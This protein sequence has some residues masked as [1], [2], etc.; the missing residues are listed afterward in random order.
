M[1]SFQT[2][3]DQK[4]LPKCKSVDAKVFLYKMRGDYHRYLAEIKAP[5]IQ[6][7]AMKL[8]EDSYDEAHAICLASSELRAS[9]PI[10]LSLALNFSVFKHEI[11]KQ[12][13]A[14]LDMAREVR[15]WIAIR[16]F[17][18]SRFEVTLPISMNF[19]LRKNIWAQLTLKYQAKTCN[20]KCSSCLIKKYSKL[21][22]YWASV[23]SASLWS[24]FEWMVSF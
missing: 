10:R 4:L 12:P 17:I 5:E 13:S 3:L 8:A 20:D 2:L 23:F 15:Q 16:S 9:H 7:D 18:M 21:G 11:L 1:F 14:A 22:V 24:V 6:M 19:I